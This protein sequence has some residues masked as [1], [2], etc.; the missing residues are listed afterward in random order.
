MADKV[1]T[2][3]R[4]A[5]RTKN[6]EKP[7]VSWRARLHEVIFEADTPIGR[8]FDIALLVA[9]V[10]SVLAVM[11]ESVADIRAQFGQVLYAI[12]WIFTILFTFEYMLRLICVRRPLRYA[13]S[14][15]G[16]VDLL[17]IAPTYL[18]LGIAG[19]HSLMV[20]R[21]LRLL[22][23]FR[24]FK[25]TR[26]LGQARLLSQALKASRPKIIVF[27]GAVL[28]MVLIMGTLLYLIEGEENGFTSIPRGVYWAI[29]TMTTVGYGD[30]APQTVLGQAMAALVMIMGYAIIAVPTGIVSAELIQELRTPTNTQVCHNC[31]LASHDDDAMFC[32]RCGSEL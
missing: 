14:F 32:K 5:I 12:E 31:A 24:V 17:A 11:L 3:K 29:V 8:A 30:I 6:E 18:S 16:V 9:I 27:I 28:S 19:A 25:L 26:Y 4:W 21:V 23:V 15:F 20:I 22:R 2:R 13:T 1:P 10:A 7:H